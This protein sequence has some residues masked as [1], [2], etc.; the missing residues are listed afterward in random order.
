MIVIIAMAVILLVSESIKPNNKNN[1]IPKTIAAGGK[2]HLFS[3]IFDLL[4]VET[5]RD[6]FLQ[7]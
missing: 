4:S 1:A 7:H 2:S 6:E 3:F 5:W